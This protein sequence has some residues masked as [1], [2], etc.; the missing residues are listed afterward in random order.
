MAGRFLYRKIVRRLLQINDTPESIALGTAMGTFIAMTPTVGI[1]MVLMIIV[2]TIIRANRVAGCVMVYI[3]N[4]FTLV[5]IYWFDYWIGS[6]TLGQSLVS[7]ERFSQELN[8]Y[9]ADIEMQKAA[10][11]FFL[12]LWHATTAFFEVQWESIVWPSVVGGSILG[13]VCA[14]PV[15]PITLRGLRAYQRRRSHRQSLDTLRVTLRE[16][17][18]EERAHLPTPD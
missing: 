15:Y 1:Q 12:G 17:R 18:L 5:P 6:V 7:Y 16:E 10:H 8:A 3:S 13:L 4:P 2:G 9:L 11:G 14:I